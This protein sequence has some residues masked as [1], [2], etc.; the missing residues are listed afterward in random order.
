MKMI[1]FLTHY[2]PF[3]FDGNPKVFNDVFHGEVIKYLI[4]SVGFFDT[5]GIMD[6]FQGIEK[7]DL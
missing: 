6:S 2:L 7:W 3:F 1:D 5:N 4:C